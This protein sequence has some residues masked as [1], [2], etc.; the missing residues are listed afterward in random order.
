MFLIN[1]FYSNNQSVTTI[2]RASK[3]VRLERC[4]KESGQKT[5][6]G[7]RILNWGEG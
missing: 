3:N 7:G 4:E 5:H 2:K 1:V 6:G